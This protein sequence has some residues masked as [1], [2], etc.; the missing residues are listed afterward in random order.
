MEVEQMTSKMGLGWSNEMMEQDMK[1]AIQWGR[2]K[3]RVLTNEMM[4]P[5]TL[6]L[7]KIIRYLDM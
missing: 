3:G 2:K 1:V 4:G 7:G 6:V 5:N